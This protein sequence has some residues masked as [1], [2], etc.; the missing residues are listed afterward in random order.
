MMKHMAKIMGGY[1]NGQTISF[2]NKPLKFGFDERGREADRTGRTNRI[3]EYTLK[4]EEPFIY[5]CAACI[6]N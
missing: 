6:Q 3:W 1:L 4:S 5:E 2:E